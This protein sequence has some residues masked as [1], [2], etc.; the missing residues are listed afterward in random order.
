M[1]KTVCPFQVVDDI[2]RSF[3]ASYAGVHNLDNLPCTS[4]THDFFYCNEAD[5][6]VLNVDQEG[7]KRKISLSLRRR[8]NTG[9][10]QVLCSIVL[11]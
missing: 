3:A 10:H 8:P 1:E 11:T 5:I 4:D 9:Q 7:V 6:V 2:Y